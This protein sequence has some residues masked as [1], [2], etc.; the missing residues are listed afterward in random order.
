MNNQKFSQGSLQVF[1][2]KAGSSPDEIQILKEDNIIVYTPKYIKTHLVST[3][4]P[5]RFVP[6]NRCYVTCVQ[7]QQRAFYKGIKGLEAWLGK[8]IRRQMLVNHQQ[9]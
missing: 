1:V 2:T 9:L 4:A 5:V 7:R 6:A 8:K 3:F